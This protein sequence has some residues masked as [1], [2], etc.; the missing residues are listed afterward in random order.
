MKRRKFLLGAT[1]VAGG[2]A[3]GYWHSQR[4]QFNPL[5]REL[6]PGQSALTPYVIVDKSG[7]TIIAPRA[8]MGQGVRTTLAALVAEELDVPLKD[9]KV[10]PGPASDVYR[11]T[12]A[13]GE[14]TSSGRLDDLRRSIFHPPP[15]WRGLQ[16]TGGQSS[17]Q[18]GFVKMREAGAAAKHVLLEAAAIELG[19]D[20][21]SLATENGFVVSND[22]RRISYGKL[23]AL[24]AT[25]ELP[26]DPKLKD[27]ANWKILGRSADR[28]DM[29]AK[30]YGTAEYSIDVQRAGM[31][32]A[33]V[34]RSPRLGGRMLGF[35]AT[36]AAG[37]PGVEKIIPFETGIMVVASNTW[38][39]ISAAKTLRIDWE[40]APYPD[41][42]QGHW[43]AI[44]K[45]L[46][47]NS[48]GPT[49][50]DGNVDAVL[51]ETEILEG[52]YRAPYLAHATMEPLNAVALLQDGQLEIWV[53]TQNPSLAAIVGARIAGIKPDDVRI[54]A[55]Y[56]GGGFGRRL[57]MDFVET[58]VRAAVAMPGIPIKMTWS[59]E[60]D[61]THGVYRPAAMASFRA[62]VSDGKAAAL[63]LRVASPSLFASFQRRTGQ[64]RQVTSDKFM[65]AGASDQPY[66]IEHYRVA[67][68]NARDL[69]PVGWWRSVGESQNSFFHESILDEMAHAARV[70][71]LQFRRDLLPDGPCRT[72]LD[73]VAQM[74][75]WGKALPKDHARGVA[76]VLSSG[77][78][79]A[80]VM[81]IS[82]GE[83]GLK[84]E[85]AFVAVD[86]GIAL[87][88]R[89]IERQIEG[90][91]IFGLTAAIRGEI[92][93][94]DG[95]VEQRNYTDYELLRIGEIPAIDV[96]IHESGNRILGAG[97][98]ATP[99]VAPALG[100]A[101]F[102]ATGNRIRELPFA[103]QVR[104][105]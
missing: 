75:D 82:S 63:E 6:A 59:R 64:S 90:S 31:L 43:D 97:E 5:N 56:L 80:M 66:D 87:D 105:V 73:A 95:V 50:D 20:A 35:D 101:I 24:A 55:M 48:L 89:N 34:R 98:S 38:Y 58:A 11:N 29:S 85:K 49:R 26:Q 103:H 17:I 69:L 92:T 46:S 16:L 51:A 7:V 79:T 104:F 41:S 37:M 74:S 22:G 102:A 40:S 44:S 84:I 47:E 10:Q 9:V 2:V 28:V 15:E 99:A 4:G 54:H 33:T 68:H 30:C 13:F 78:P 81:Q 57:E 77:A 27:P 96:L 42:M 14:F 52:E 25:L 8:E 53:G 39:A 72:V 88:P 45:A 19:I 70:D 65:T 93:V 32:Y 83:Y 61:M 60:E 36:T 1:A 21:A 91:L 100:N 71:P 94:A 86:V 23:A 12:V 67:A 3:V 62:A 76:F 18:D